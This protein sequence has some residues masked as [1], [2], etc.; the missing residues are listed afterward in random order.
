MHPEIKNIDAWNNIY[1]TI[2]KKGEKFKDKFVIKLIDEIVD[3]SESNKL[4]IFDIF[5]EKLN[6]NF[7]VKVSRL[8]QV[9]WCSHTSSRLPKSRQTPVNAHI[10]HPK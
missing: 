4:S 5:A 1:K 10:K 6:K 3:S 7:V 2:L 8:Q 9:F